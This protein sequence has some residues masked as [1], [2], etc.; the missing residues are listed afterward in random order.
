MAQ[1]KKLKKNTKIKII[2]AVSF[3]AVLIGLA[4]FL[5]SGNNAG[6]LRE[7]FNP[8]ISSEQLR[9]HLARLGYKGYITVGVLAMLQ[10]LLTFLPAEPVQVAAGMSFGINIGFLCCLGGVI[11]G[12]TILYLLYKTYGQGIT[13]YFETNVCLALDKL[14]VFLSLTYNY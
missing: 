10:V 12:N 1:Q 9:Q 2:L 11:V 4:F 7:L 14:L 5:F 13:D 8:N 6:I 3:L